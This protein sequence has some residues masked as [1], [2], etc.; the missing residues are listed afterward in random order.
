MFQTGKKNIFITILINIAILFAVLTIFYLQYSMDLTL[1][2]SKLLNFMFIIPIFLAVYRFGTIYGM[3][4]GAAALVCYIVFPNWS[5]AI[6]PPA[7]LI[8]FC[9]M[10]ISAIV[11]A[12]VSSVRK[13]IW[14]MSTE[15]KEK[16][17]LVKKADDKSNSDVLEVLIK[18]I[19]AKDSYTYQHSRR[20]AYYAKCL[21]MSSG[22]S[23]EAADRVYIAGMLH[24]IGKIGLNENILNKSTK[25]D[26]NERQ[27][28]SRH[29]I[30]GARIAE[31]LNC[32][33]DVI[34]GIYYHHEVYN[35]SGYPEGLKGNAIPLTARILSI[36]DAFDAMTSDRS[37]RAGMPVE[38]AVKRLI[39]NIGNQFDPHLIV[40]FIDLIKN[41]A[42]YIESRSIQSQNSKKTVM[43]EVF[44][45]L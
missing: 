26:E 32:F 35:G 42:I 16:N 22:L 29:P 7:L 39:E 2:E 20:V 34:P 3:G 36:A 18:V 27:E 33:K 6:Y 1:L 38:N 9:Q 43:D 13:K 37:Y 25:L 17:E 8:L 31:N 30:I 21:A 4:V 24:D 10:L 41:K 12:F 44:D 19:D 23:E 14:V 5:D 28:A 15:I 40:T 45:N 11:F